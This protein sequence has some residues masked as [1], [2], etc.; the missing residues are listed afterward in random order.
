MAINKKSLTDQVYSMLKE[1]ILNRDV[2]LG[3]Q[4]NTREIA[5]EHGISLMPVRDALRRLANEDLV[6]N[7]PRVGFFVKN[8]S[9]AEVNDILEVRKMHEIYCLDNYF[10]EIDREV[11]SDLKDKFENGHKKYFTSY[12]SKLHKEIV[13]ASHNNYLIDSYLKMINHYTMLFSY[14]NYKRS[15]TSRQEHIDIIDSI[16]KGDKAKAEEILYRHLDRVKIAKDA[17]I[18]N[19]A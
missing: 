19:R 12:D 18:K 2:D 8:F 14:L 16:L 3:E 13:L 7:R 6:E 10:A 4:L 9:E 5:E 17:S 11:I 1:K 15:E